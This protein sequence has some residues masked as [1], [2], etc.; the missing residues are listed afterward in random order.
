MRSRQRVCTYCG[1]ALATSKDHVPPKG[2]FPPPRPSLLTVPSCE[3]CNSGDA[4]DDEYFRF[5]I[6]NAAVCDGQPSVEAL[7]HTITRSLAK[8]EAVGFRS[9]LLK[10]IV[11]PANHDPS[12]NYDGP[13]PSGE[14]D[15]ARMKR[16]ANRILR[17]FFFIQ[18]N[19]RHIPDT[20]EV[21]TFIDDEH[22]FFGQHL[23]KMFYDTLNDQSEQVIGDGSVFRYS[24]AFPSSEDVDTSVWGFLYYNSY[25]TLSIV[26]R[27]RLQKNDD[28]PSKGGQLLIV[29]A[30]EAPSPRTRRPR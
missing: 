28:P 5:V 6:V 16:I 21:M 24:V 11:F 18:T 3:N 4:E 2:M 14:V 25:L 13:N 26:R 12:G 7:R 23:A 10:S 22:M 9:S 1:K 15:L 20:H 17:A 27:R 8:P 29:P 30:K 19:G